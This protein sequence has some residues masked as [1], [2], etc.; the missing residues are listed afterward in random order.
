ME[1]DPPHLDSQPASQVPNRDGSFHAA[2]LHPDSAAPPVLGPPFLAHLE[3]SAPQLP[4]QQ[5]TETA[6]QLPIRNGTSNMPPPMNVNGPAA[7]S[8]YPDAQ[9]QSQ[10]QSTSPEPVHPAPGSAPHSPSGSSAV[11]KRNQGE[12]HITLKHTAVTGQMLLSV[13]FHSALR[14]YFDNKLITDAKCL[15]KVAHKLSLH[16]KIQC[17]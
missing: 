2:V 8:D 7:A 9:D 6:P 11:W 14:G 4:T 12:P 13:S 1:Q 5:L 10:T 15:H 3:T 16:C 17:I